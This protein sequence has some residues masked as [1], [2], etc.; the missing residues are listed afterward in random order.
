M[1]RQD[2]TY[3]KYEE[4]GEI[5]LL[6]DNSYPIPKKHCD[7]VQKFLMQKG[8]EFRDE[9]KNIMC[10]MPD[11]YFEILDP[12]TKD[13]NP[14]IE[15]EYLL[16]DMK[17]YIKVVPGTNL[18]KLIWKIFKIPVEEQMDKTKTQRMSSKKEDDSK[19]YKDLKNNFYWGLHGN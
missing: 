6:P 19:K 5:S 16:G 15:G 9:H 11:H 4:Q 7:N 3:K 1:S 2:K 8:Y 10:P 14:V 18:E 13:D 12:T 17:S